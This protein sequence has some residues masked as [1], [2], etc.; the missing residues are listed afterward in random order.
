M[1]LIKWQITRAWLQIPGRKPPPKQRWPRTLQRDQGENSEFLRI[2]VTLFLS[3]FFPRNVAIFQFINSL[4]NI[5][6]R[7][8]WLYGIT[9]S[10]GMS[11][12]KLWEL[13][14]DREA[15]DSCVRKEWDMTEQLN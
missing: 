6:Q 5:Q 1:E 8:R 14:M 4:L 9:D 12:S 7:M 11:L 10:M 2:T 15:C 3:F 13:V